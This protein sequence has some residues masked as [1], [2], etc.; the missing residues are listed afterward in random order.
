[1][2]DTKNTNTKKKLP[3]GK[4]IAKDEI[5]SQER[6][7][8]ETIKTPQNAAEIKKEKGYLGEAEED[9]GEG[10]KTLGGKA[11][12]L[13]DIVVDKLKKGPRNTPTSIKLNRKSRN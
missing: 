11:T 5:S 1:M 13:S 8:Q 2:S 9:V 6:P 12:E 3:A 4:E 10:A 7:G